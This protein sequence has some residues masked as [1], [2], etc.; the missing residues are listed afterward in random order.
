MM[1]ERTRRASRWCGAVTVGALVTTTLALGA[2]SARDAALDASDVSGAAR[3]V[4]SG[5]YTKA[6]AQRGEAAFRAYCAGCHHPDQFVGPAFLSGWDGRPMAELFD[7]VRETMPQDNPGSLRREDYVDV[8]AYL[9]QLNGLPE[10]KA[11]LPTEDAALKQVIME[12][13]VETKGAGR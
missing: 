7:T 1:T 8:L 3:S 6:Q 4:R 5:V 10:G 11:E 13:P 9:L 12:G 2:W